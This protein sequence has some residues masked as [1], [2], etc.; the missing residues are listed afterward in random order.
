MENRLTEGERREA[1]DK[2]AELTKDMTAA[3][4]RKVF[5]AIR[6]GRARVMSQEELDAL[7]EQNAQ[8]VDAVPLKRGGSSRT[9]PTNTA[10][11][12]AAR[13]RNRTS[14]RSRARNRR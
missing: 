8:G 11:K 9:A 6:E 10:Q 4:R 5:K 1:L 3:E 13:K 14:A 12:K 2:L 7:S